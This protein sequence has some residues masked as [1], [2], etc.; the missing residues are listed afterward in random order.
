MVKFSFRHVWKE[1]PL[2]ISAVAALCLFVIPAKIVILLVGAVFCCVFGAVI[3]GISKPEPFTCKY[4][5]AL[6]WVIAVYAAAVGFYQ[7]YNSWIHS[8]LLAAVGS[9]V[10]IRVEM[11]AA[12][13]AVLGCGVGLYALH[14]LGCW[15]VVFVVQYLPKT[16]I[17]EMKAGFKRNWYFPLSVLAFFLLAQVLPEEQA[18][19][20]YTAVTADYFLGLP[21]VLLAAG[22]AATQMR[23][24]KERRKDDNAFWTVVSCLTAVG[25]CVARYDWSAKTPLCMVWAMMAGPAVYD[26]VSALWRYF[27]KTFRETGLFAGV[28][29]WEKVLYA[30]LLGATL[31]FMAVVFLKTDA[32]YDTAYKYDIIF[33]SDSPIL[34]R[35]NVYM[36][37]THSQNDLRQPIFAVCA[38]P[39]VGWAYLVHQIS[40]AWGVI[41]M[42][43]AQIAMMFAANFML[44]KA[45]KLEGLGRV[46]FMVLLCCGYPYLLFSL[47]MEQYIVAYFWLV[48]AV[49]LA[50]T[51]GKTDGIAYVGATGSLLTS[52]VLLPLTSQKHPVKEFWGWFWDMVNHGVEFAMA[53]VIL[54]RLDVIRNLAAKSDVLGQF[55]GKELTLMDK[56]CQYTAFIGACFTA[57]AA[58]INHEVAAGASWQLDQVTGI[59]V[60][61]IGILV[62]ALVSAVV[63]R[64]KLSSRIAAAWVAFSVVVLCVLGWGTQ[65]NG[66]ILYA[67]YFGWA[68]AMLLF[69]LVQRIGEKTKAAMGLPAVS[70]A[71]VIWL[72]VNNVPAMAQLLNFAVTYYAR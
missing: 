56:F 69:Q 35:E 62:L 18:L 68:F 38:A 14:R 5:K 53:M 51:K 25:I 32:F 31:V 20:S 52:A 41:C 48:L 21:A 64:E 40:P 34:V 66:L 16:E 58:G 10:G 17:E 23:G 24:P 65:E 30:L 8:S 4:R 13:V 45:M 28:G 61:G 11:V 49:Y 26:C 6:A 67:L 36:N 42:N 22:A 47:M 72:L 57:P 33:T 3:F 59:S 43:A 63:N 29:R 27:R 70:A 60:L 15:I 12:A 7:F 1:M 46:C 44:C 19:E 9:I 54:G 39:F 37:L 50:C 2:L 71:A 55:T